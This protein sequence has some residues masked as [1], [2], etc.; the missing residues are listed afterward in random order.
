MRIEWTCDPAQT[1]ALVQRVLHEIDFVRNISFQ[2]GQ[3]ARIRDALQHDYEINSQENGYLLGQISRRYEN[4]EI[5]DLATVT[6]YPERL[7]ELSGAAVHAA[8][9]KYL[10]TSNYVKVIL[11]PDGK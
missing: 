1:D 6:N 4:G 5:A 10:D 3:V 11:M 9:M 7:T 8:A 2:P